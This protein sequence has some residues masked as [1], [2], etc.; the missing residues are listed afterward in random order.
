MAPRVAK[1]T[2]SPA[3]DEHQRDEDD[4]DRHDGVGHRREPRQ[5]QRMVVEGGAGHLVAQ[6]LPQRIEIGLRARRRASCTIRRGTGRSPKSRPVP[7]QGSSSRS[8]SPG[9]GMRPA[10][11]RPCRGRGPPRGPRPPRCPAADAGAPGSSP[12]GRRRSAIRRSSRRRVPPQPAQS[13][14]RKVRIAITADSARPPAEST[15]TRGALRRREA[16]SGARL[17]ARLRCAARRARGA[18]S[19]RSLIALTR[20]YA[21]GRRRARGGARR[22]GPSGRG[23]GSR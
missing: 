23:R 12:R 6:G 21:A 14:A 11:S 17:G 10:R 3:A 18:G 22:A 13:A 20:R 9:E 1:V 19:F 8:D 5:P 15:G 4:P 16:G 2:A 7:S